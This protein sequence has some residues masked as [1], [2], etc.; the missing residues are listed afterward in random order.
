MSENEWKEQ[1]KWKEK[2]LKMVHVFKTKNLTHCDHE[3]I[4]LKIIRNAMI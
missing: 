2:K 4:Y 3:S 1:E